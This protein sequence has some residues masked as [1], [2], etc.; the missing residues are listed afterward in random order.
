MYGCLFQ[1]QIVGYNTDLYGNFTQASSS[2]YGLTYIGLL[3]QVT[4]F[5]IYRKMNVK[6]PPTFDFFLERKMNFKEP[7]KIVYV[8]NEAFMSRFFCVYF[9]Y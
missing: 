5:I 7:P 8:L 6:E 3:V 9:V 2:P 4:H 1:I